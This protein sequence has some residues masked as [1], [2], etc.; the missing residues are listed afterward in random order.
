MIVHKLDQQRV[1]ILK[2]F[3]NPAQ[4]PRRNNAIEDP[5]IGGKRQENSRS[6][7]NPIV[8]HHRPLRDLASREDD[9]LRW[10]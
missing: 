6:S 5:V 4:K 10:V 7:L 8:D 9:T 1:R 2:Q 3:A